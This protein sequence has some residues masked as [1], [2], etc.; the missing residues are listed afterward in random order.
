MSWLFSR[1]L[2]EEYSEGICS[3]GK[4]YAPSSGTPTPRAYLSHGKM[5]AFSR[6]SRFGM[7]CARLTDD[8]GEDLLTSF[9]EAFRVRTLARPEKAPESTESDLECGRTWQG[10]LAKYDLATCSWKIAQCSLVEGLDV[11]SETWPRWGTMRAGVCW[12]LSTPARLTNASE[13]GSKPNGVSFFNTPT[14][15]GLDGG[16][17]SRRALK[18]RQQSTYPTPTAHD[19]RDSGLSPSQ[20]LRRSTTLPVAVGGSLNP[21]WVEWLMGWPPGWTDYAPLEMDKYRQWLRLHGRHYPSSG[22]ASSRA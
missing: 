6:L 21:N 19:A 18:K 7:T 5:T 1:V 11:F 12:E 3:D 10:S 13:Y 9:R 4:P 16:S 15:E 14:T 20:F 2:V 8:R 17:N 22:D